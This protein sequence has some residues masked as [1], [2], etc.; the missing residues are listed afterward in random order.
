MED[1]CGYE[2]RRLVVVVVGTLLLLDEEMDSI[3]YTVNLVKNRHYKKT[4]SN[5]FLRKRSLKTLFIVGVPDWHYVIAI[6]LSKG[7]VTLDGVGPPTSGPP[8]SDRSPYICIVPC[9]PVSDRCTY[10]VRRFTYV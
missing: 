6:S 5:C 8:S 7:S 10:D 9:T 2:Y 4:Y 3:C 1:R